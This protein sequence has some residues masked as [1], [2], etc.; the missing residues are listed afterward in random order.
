MW[1]MEFNDWRDERDLE[2]GLP[3]CVL[4]FSPASAGHC[5]VEYDV[6]PQEHFSPGHKFDP[7]SWR[8]FNRSPLTTLLA[9]WFRIKKS[10]AGL[11]WPLAVKSRCALMLLQQLMSAALCFNP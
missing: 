9:E 5:K 6:I 7:K 4:R 1:I 10:V 8:R 3:L 2:H 11:K